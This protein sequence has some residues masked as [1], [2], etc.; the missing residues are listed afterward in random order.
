MK[1]NTNSSRPSLKILMRLGQIT[2]AAFI[3]ITLPIAGFAQQTTAD[4]NGAV[5]GADGSA[6]A[7]ASVE[8]LHVG[9]GIRRTTT[10]NES[11][12]FHQSGL[13]PGGPYTVT[14]VGTDVR[15]EGVYLNISAPTNVYLAPPGA[16]EEIV[17]LGV[18]ADG[19]LRMGASTM[20]SNQ[21]LN[22]AASIAR[23]FKNIIRTDPRVAIDP[24]NQNAIV[25][26]GVNNRL[27]SLTVDGIRQ[28]DEF[29]LNQSGFPTQRGPVS[30]DAIEQISVEIAPFS[31]EYGG[32]QGGTINIVT[33]SGENDFHGSVIFNRSH[34]GLIGD[35]SENT[36][37]NIGEFEEEFLSVTFGGPIVK[38]R[39][40][41]F[42]SYEKFEGSDPDAVLFGTEGSGRAIE[43][44]GVTDAEYAVISSP[45]S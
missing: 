28:N 31:V 2:L 26:G 30:I 19:G 27:N 37:I 11:G 7:G 23:D 42:A 5:Y 21:D 38:D 14:V 40:W 4:L 1:N 13:R 43:I 44:E 34:D 25:I 6:T 10:T 45:R 36:A 29:G 12:T 18:Q 22:E 39:L 20:I 17:V 16:I 8:I 35:M 9:T 15:E 3:L 24:T 41:F 33:K 32:F